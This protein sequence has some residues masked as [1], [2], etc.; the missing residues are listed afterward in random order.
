MES[1]T[2]D[3]YVRCRRCHG[4]FEST[5]ANCPRCGTAHIAPA[6]EPV[7]EG[8]Y[9]DRYEGTQFAEASAPQP[10]GGGPRRS[11]VGILLAIGVALIVTAICVSALVVMGAFDVPTPS[12]TA[13]NNIVVSKATPTPQPTMPPAIANTLDQLT[14]PNMNLHVTIRTT[15]SVNAKVTGRSLS[16]MVNMEIDCAEGNESGTTKTGSL[17]TEWRLVDGVYYTRVGAG[18][19]TARAGMSPFV[20]LSP[21]FQLDQPRMLQYDGPDQQNGFL[22]EK[23][24]T[25]DWWTPDTSKL[26]GLDV[27]MLAIS[28]QHTK[29]QLWVDSGGTPV[30][31]TFRAWTDASDGTNLL[32]IATTYTFTNI[33]TV[34]PIATPKL[35]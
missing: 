35:K 7:E 29:L 16:T 5:L 25:T 18:K 15:V 24:E 12:P 2:E 10:T 33:G 6:D 23:L 11:T 26:S 20:V 17:T 30:Y 1:G 8:S 9:V 3:R 21:M 14:D 4:A 32:T 27:A 22:A 13:N 19:W 31:A 34:E 28:P